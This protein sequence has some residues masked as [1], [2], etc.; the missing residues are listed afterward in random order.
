MTSSAYAV[1]PVSYEPY[2]PFFLGEL[3]SLKGIRIEV[4]NQ[5]KCGMFYAL[6]LWVQLHDSAEAADPVRFK[7]GRSGE[8][9]L[10]VYGI[11][12]IGAEWSMW[13]MS[14]DQSG[15]KFVSRPHPIP[16]CGRR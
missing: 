14:Y 15:K 12:T 11:S 2:F 4:E 6:N 7:T 1:L 3:K 5:I 8:S 13:M 9:L 10:K 16:S